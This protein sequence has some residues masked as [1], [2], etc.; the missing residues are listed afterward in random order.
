MMALPALELRIPSPPPTLLDAVRSFNREHADDALGIPLEKVAGQQYLDAMVAR[1]WPT[2]TRLADTI[3]SLIHHGPGAVVVRNLGFEDY[4]PDTQ[5]SLLLALT[6]AIG[7]PTDHAKDRRVLWPIIER[8][9]RPGRVR[10]F[11]ERTGEAPFHTDSAFAPEPELYNGLYV[12]RRAGCGGGLSRLISAQGVIDRLAATADGPRCIKLLR[13]LRFPFQ[14][15]EAFY[16]DGPR[17]ITA[18][19]LADKPMI[20]FRPDSIQNGFEAMPELASE[21]H[22]WAFRKVWEAIET[23]PEVLEYMLNDGEFIV[24]DNHRL[25]HARGDYS[26]PLRHLVRIRM[27]E[28][29]RTAQHFE[30]RAAALVQ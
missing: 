1:T 23:H 15:P 22:R 16:R 6:S 10:T 14:I 30:H 8:A 26:D 12:V 7:M 2:I 3:R 21:Q 20:R 28:R 24:F 25:L 17:V 18:P 19:I 4:E 5:A 29:I 27:A 13:T 9:P 11:S